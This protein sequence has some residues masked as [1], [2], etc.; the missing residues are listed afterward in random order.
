MTEKNAFTLLEMMIVLLI[1][2][3]ILLI[4]IPNIAQKEKIIREKGCRSL[5]KTVDS[6]ILLYEIDN[7]AMPSMQDLIQK[8]YLK[9]EQA[10]CPNGESVEIVDGQA[11]SR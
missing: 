8:G 6:Q 10:K 1:I 4:T 11:I 2:T 9:E 7:D 3:V 5:L